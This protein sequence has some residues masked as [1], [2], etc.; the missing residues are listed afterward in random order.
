MEEKLVQKIN[1]M[2]KLNL[3]KE[4]LVEA[5]AEFN[6]IYGMV[7][8]VVEKNRGVNLNESATVENMFPQFTGM[9]KEINIELKS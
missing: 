5:H 8:A 9:L 2:Q 3:T 4:E 1:T 7:M 6:I